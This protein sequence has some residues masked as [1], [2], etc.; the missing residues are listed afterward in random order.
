MACA[1]NS[2]NEDKGRANGVSCLGCATKSPLIF[3]DLVIS[4]YIIAIMIRSSFK[5]L[6]HCPDVKN[7]VG[8]VCA[9]GCSE[10]DRGRELTEVRASEARDR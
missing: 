2:E 5:L 6:F 4:C 9:G 1:E 7:S 3:F 8:W 10:R